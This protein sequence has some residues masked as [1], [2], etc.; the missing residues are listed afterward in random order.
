MPNKVRDVLVTAIQGAKFPDEVKISNPSNI[1][2][3]ASVFNSLNYVC[4]KIKNFQYII[5]C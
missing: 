1:Y 3:D 4:G 2:A 5:D